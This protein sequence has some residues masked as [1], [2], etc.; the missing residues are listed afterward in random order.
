MFIRV[1]QASSLFFDCPKYA[2]YSL[3]ILIIDTISSNQ[4]IIVSPFFN[5]YSNSCKVF[6]ILCIKFEKSGVAR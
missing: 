6:G 1:L 5:G 3:G 2:L 4:V